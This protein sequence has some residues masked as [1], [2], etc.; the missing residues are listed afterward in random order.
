MTHGPVEVTFYVFEDFLTYKSGV[1]EHKTGQF[2]GSHAVK[3]IGWGVENGIPYWIVVNSWN[4][5]WGDN[6][7]FKILRGK[8]HC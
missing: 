6:G 2:L 3:M 1:Y 7:T 8:N 4:E 5:M